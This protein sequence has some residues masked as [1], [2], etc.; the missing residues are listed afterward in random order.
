MSNQ[1]KIVC[2]IVNRVGAEAIFVTRDHAS[3]TEKYRIGNVEKWGR[4]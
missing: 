2:P 3:K 4:V 1:I